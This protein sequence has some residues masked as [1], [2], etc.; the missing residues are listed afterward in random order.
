MRD[1]AYRYHQ[2]KTHNDRTA[3]DKRRR[4]HHTY[5]KTV[6]RI[7]RPNGKT[8]GIVWKAQDIKNIEKLQSQIEE[9]NNDR[10]RKPVARQFPKYIN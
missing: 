2:N 1:K 8:E 9:S 5:K 4:C 10:I 7:K 6:K 3:S